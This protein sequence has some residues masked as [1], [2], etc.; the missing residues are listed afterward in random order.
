MFK[1]ESQKQI[2]ALAKQYRQK[3]KRLSWESCIKKAKLAQR[4]FNQE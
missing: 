2:E 1:S 4:R 3:D